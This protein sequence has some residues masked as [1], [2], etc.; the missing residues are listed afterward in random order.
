MTTGKKKIIKTILFSVLIVIVTAGFIGYKM[1]TKP[2]RNV[3]EAKGIMVTATQL[4][5]AYET[6]EPDANTRYLDKILE[7]TG[8]VT[9][10]NKNQKN[11]TVVTLK[12]SDMSSIICTVEAPATAV[13][14]N[15]STVVAKGICTGYLADVVLV[16]C[17]LATN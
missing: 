9:G 6:N 17:V 2:H 5:N 1:Y 11:E 10:I 3:Q 16:H 7:V 14:A 8:T 4:A 15:G 13:P 12:G